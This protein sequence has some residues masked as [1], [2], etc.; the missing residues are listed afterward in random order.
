[1]LR[2]SW[3]QPYYP[4]EEGAYQ[5][6]LSCQG[7]KIP[8][9]LK[10][11]GW[12]ATCS[13]ETPALWPYSCSFFSLGP[14]PF[15]LPFGPRMRMSPSNAHTKKGLKKPLH[16]CMGLSISPAPSTVTHTYSGFCLGV[17]NTP[18]V[19]TQVLYR[20]E[21]GRFR[22]QR[23][24]GITNKTGGRLRSLRAMLGKSI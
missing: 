17:R 10:P 4:R 18:I 14:A 1:M 7:S 13:V 2:R 22:Q 16:N 20:I 15:S 5:E 3:A 6:C 21:Y 23:H 8:T 19:L 24:F 12:T 11:E 9:L